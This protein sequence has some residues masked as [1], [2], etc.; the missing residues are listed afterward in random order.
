MAYQQITTTINNIDRTEYIIM[1]SLSINDE[2]TSTINTCS[3]RSYDIDGT[4][5][6]SISD[7][8][9]IYN[10]DETLIFAGQIA[11]VSETRIGIN[12]D[13]G[14][15]L[16]GYSVSCQDYTKILQRKLV[17]ETY[18]NKTC[19]TILQEMVD[20]YFPQEGIT[21]VNTE[22]GP[23]VENI[24]FNYQSA[25]R[26]IETLADSVGFQW[27]IDY[28][29]DIHF[30]D[31]VGAPTTL[32]ITDST[33]NWSDLKI[34]PDTSQL[35]NRVY[36]RGGIY[37]S[38][39]YTQNLV[40]DGEQEEFILAYTP[41]DNGFSLTVN[42]TSRTVGLDGIDESDSF[43]FLLTRK[44]KALKMGRTAWALANTP[45]A[46]NAVLSITYNYEI[47]VLVVQE[48]SSSISA[49]K[50]LEGGDG[51]YEFLVVDENITSISA[52]RARAAAELRDFANPIIRGSVT[53]YDAA[54]VTSGDLLSIN[55]TRRGINSTYLIQSVK[56]TQITTDTLK[57]TV[58][59]SGKLYGLVDVFISLFKQS[60]RVILGL[61]EVL[62]AFNTLSDSNNGIY[63]SVPI[64]TESAPPFAWSN[65]E[66]TTTNKIR[67]SLFE[68]S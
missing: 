41:D 46:A 7:I 29:K 8:I 50:T 45:L 63:H 43:D 1:G 49:M 40:A 13:D 14:E 22:E 47:P 19:K 17:I 51:V 4:W 55:L 9:K 27:Y 36:I 56:I 57:Y 3:F 23:L 20:K 48:S 18:H 54:G 61:D 39:P 5:T 15:E 2:L 25:D 24:T 59:F 21:F 30:F 58:D 32:T 6:P 37:Y 38:D 26:M 53:S 60:Q 28:E 62:D 34:N 31:Q 35:R 42:A 52:A 12:P 11:S 16:L 10:L 65:D 33:D 67:W 44:E 66:G 68:W 64:L